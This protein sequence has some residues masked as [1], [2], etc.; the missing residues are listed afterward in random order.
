[1]NRSGMLLV[2]ILCGCTGNENAKPSPPA[3]SSTTGVAAEGAVETGSP[4]PSSAIREPLPGDWFED[5][6]S[7]TSVRFSSANGRESDRFTILE[8]VGSGVGLVDFDTDGWSDLY[9]AGGGRIDRETVQPTGQ[10]GGLFRN[11]GNWRFEDSTSTA[12][13]PASAAYSHGVLT[14]DVN[15]DGAP[16]LFVT[17]FGRNCLLINLGD[18]TFLDRTD[19][20]GLAGSGWSTAAA[21][22]DVDGDGLLDLFVVRY[23]EWKPDPAEVCRYGAD[24]VPDVCP[25]Q[26]YKPA[27][28]L[29]YINQGNGTFL[30]SGE[31]FGIRKDGKG[32]GVVA[33]DLNQDGRAD[34]Y[35]A[36]DQVENHLYL[37]APM[38]AL[39]EQ[40]EISG[41]ARNETGTPEGSMGVDA[42]DVDGDGRIDLWVTNFELEDNSLYQ[43]LGNGQ[44]LH[45]TTT[46]GL[47][48]RGR[49][50]VG[51]GTGLVDFNSDGWL[52]LY[53]LNGHVWYRH[54]VQPFRQA[55]HLFRSREGRQFEDVSAAGGPWFAG[56]HAARGGATGDLDHDGAPDLVVSSLDEPIVILRNRLPTANWIRLKL[57]G[58]TAPRDPV[59]ARVTLK[60][61]N[62]PNV[63]VLNSGAG[64][65]SQSDSRLLIALSDSQTAVD[66]TIDWPDGMSERFTGLTAAQYH[67]VIQG[68]G[69]PVTAASAVSR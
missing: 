42:G 40:G 56:T 50:A 45:S 24:Q 19:S 49:G 59:G 53:V 32:L 58:T 54:G 18:G 47:A 66:L 34:F 3:G 17:G 15:D 41:T 5:V 31:R 6:T 11:P 2:L 28:D 21:A 27:S 39:V 26:N 60:A 48:G 29:F 9:C 68:R 51:F 57:V 61:F 46:F 30:E 44:F 43:S 1:M 14:G 16:D 33:T 10:P 25:P 64:Y 67:V 23:V 13:A 52:D 12:R 22:G 55:P 37:S 20:S 8:T 62:R 38:S 35:V 69:Q 7:R 63:R 4:R 65:L 36:N